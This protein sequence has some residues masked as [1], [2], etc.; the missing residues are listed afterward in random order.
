MIRDK[1][2]GGKLVVA[3]YVG[4]ETAWKDSWIVD[5]LVH[6]NAWGTRDPSSEYPS[7]G[8]TNLHD[9]KA[10]AAV[11]RPSR[12]LAAPDVV[13]D[14][15]QCFTQCRGYSIPPAPP[16]FVHGQKLFSLGF[17]LGGGNTPT[18]TTGE[19]VGPYHDEDGG[20]VKFMGLVMPGHSGGC[21][22]DEKGVVVGWNV[23]NIEDPNPNPRPQ[24]FGSAGLNH[25][26]SI[27]DAQPILEAVQAKL[28]IA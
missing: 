17:P 27:A 25:L 5:V 28:G 24:Y 23:R 7:E 18:P 4:G 26:R 22:V 14:P 13:V 12:K 21:V 15:G 8:A 19:Y 16:V 20:W 6:T 2:P 1:F 3:L 10:D 9:S 11:L